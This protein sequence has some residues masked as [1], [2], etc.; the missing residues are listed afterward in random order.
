MQ[1]RRKEVV[2]DAMCYD[3]HNYDDIVLWMQRDGQ[4][5]VRAQSPA[6]SL[7][8]II[9]AAV[10]DL[11]VGPGDWII[12]KLG[13]EFSTIRGV[14]FAEMYEV[15]NPPIDTEYTFNMDIAGALTCLRDGLKVRRAG[16]NDKGSWIVLMG[17]LRLPPHS[18]QAPGA[19]VNDRTAKYIGADTPLDSQPYIA[20]YTSDGKWQPGWVCSQADLLA[21]DWQTVP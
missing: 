7:V 16:W 13:G 2:V 3:G 6:G 18:S 8:L 17:A 11:H 20:L 5:P 10:C 4:R 12:R 9:H 15:V 21:E 14:V 1:F 19:K